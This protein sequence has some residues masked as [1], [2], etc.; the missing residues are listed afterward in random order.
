MSEYV[1][2]LFTVST[3]GTVILLNAPPD[4]KP[5]TNILRRT[6]AVGWRAG[7]NPTTGSYKFVFM[8]GS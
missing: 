6:T 8:N 1:D 7:S 3:N 2:K 5:T 4:I